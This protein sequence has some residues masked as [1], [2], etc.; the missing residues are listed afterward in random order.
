MSAVSVILIYVSV[1][2]YLSIGI[3]YKKIT[4]YHGSVI[5]LFFIIFILESSLKEAVILW[6]FAKLVAK[7]QTYLTIKH[8]IVLNIFT[9]KIHFISVHIF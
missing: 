4:L 9:W 8:R 3:A 7:G 1:T 2:K 6:D 5:V